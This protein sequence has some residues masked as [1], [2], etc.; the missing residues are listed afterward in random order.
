M[1]LAGDLYHTSS[2][3]DFDQCIV[4]SRVL[5]Q[6][7]PEVEGEKRDV[8]RINLDNLSADHRAFLV[9]HQLAEIKHL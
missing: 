9:L 4:G 7:L 1:L 2:F 3:Q 5:A 6:L 8:A